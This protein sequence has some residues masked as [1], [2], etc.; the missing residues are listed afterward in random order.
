MS[1]APNYLRFKLE[2]KKGILSLE[3]I[4]SK[5]GKFEAIRILI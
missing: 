5:E 3:Q 4:E 2:K 1:I